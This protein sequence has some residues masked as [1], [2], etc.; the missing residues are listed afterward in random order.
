M[1]KKKKNYDE[2]TFC[3]KCVCTMC[4]ILGLFTL[5]G[6]ERQETAECVI[7]SLSGLGMMLASVAAYWW[8]VERENRKN[9]KRY[10]E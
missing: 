7:N 1:E 5:G 8:Y 4:F 2:S 10:Y 3:I 9:K 6:T